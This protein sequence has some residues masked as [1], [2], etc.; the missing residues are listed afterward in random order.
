MFKVFP[1]LK[2]ITENEKWLRKMNKSSI[3]KLLFEDGVYDMDTGEFKKEFD[4]KIFFSFAIPHK[5]PEYNKEKIKRAMKISFDSLFDKQNQKRMIM[6]LAT[7]L[8]GKPLKRMFFCPG[9]TNAGK[10]KFRYSSPIYIIT[11]NVITKFQI[12]HPKI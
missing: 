9:D 12:I 3:G 5:F 10:S 1:Y 2:S 4:P 6:S 7:A 8:Y 11:I